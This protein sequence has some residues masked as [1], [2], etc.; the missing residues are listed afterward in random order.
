MYEN[1][2]PEETEGNLTPKY[3]LWH[4]SEANR[5]L[6]GS[7]GDESYEFIIRFEND[8]TTSIYFTENELEIDETYYSTGSGLNPIYL[9]FNRVADS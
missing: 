8:E 3:A 4:L 5:Q 6:T 7:I 2:D 9:L 1:Y